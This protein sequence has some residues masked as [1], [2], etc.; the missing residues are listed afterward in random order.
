MTWVV[1]LAVAWVCVGVVVSLVVCLA[2]RRA[3]REARHRRMAR[4]SAPLVPPTRLGRL[5]SARS[6][7]ARPRPVAGRTADEDRGPSPS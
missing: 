1:G 6:P 5:A 3:D 2:I 7:A 4:E